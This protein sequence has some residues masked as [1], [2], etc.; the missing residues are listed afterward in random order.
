[1]AGMRFCL[2][3]HVRLRFP[4]VLRCQVDVEDVADDKGVHFDFDDDEMKP[5]ND[6]EEGELPKMEQFRTEAEQDMF[7]LTLLFAIFG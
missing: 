3:L 4:I 6:E 7:I 1:M 2:R 5:L